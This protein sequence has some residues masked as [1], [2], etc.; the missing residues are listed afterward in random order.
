M[1]GRPFGMMGLAERERLRDAGPF[2]L[3]RAAALRVGL[4]HC[5][6][7]TNNRVS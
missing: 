5:D 6:S 3:C 2:L 7:P 1:S 4:P